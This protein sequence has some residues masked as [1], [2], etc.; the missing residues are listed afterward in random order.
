MDFRFL[1]VQGTESLKGN[2]TL[3]FRDGMREDPTASVFAGSDLILIDH[4]KR[5]VINMQE[6]LDFQEFQDL[7]SGAMSSIPKKS[8]VTDLQV[9]TGPSRRGIFKKAVVEK[10]SGY[11][12][13]KF[14]FN[15]HS[16]VSEVIMKTKRD[17]LKG[18]LTLE[19]YEDIDLRCT[20]IKRVEKNKV[21][22]HFWLTPA[23]PLKV[24]GLLNMFRCFVGDENTQKEEEGKQEG[25]ENVLVNIMRYLGSAELQK[26]SAEHGFPVKMHIPLFYSLKGKVKIEAF[27]PLSERGDI[28]HVPV[29]YEGQYRREGLNELGGRL[30]KRK[31]KTIIENGSFLMV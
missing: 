6:P 7:I 14:R 4:D 18:G 12:A 31:A 21:K 16:K 20:H 15:L 11:K 22:L 13:E 8:I 23:I 10:V 29:G 30:E 27:K 2:L 17:I 3:L 26:L 1:G 24:E 25:G 28:F 5:T 9:A 19:K